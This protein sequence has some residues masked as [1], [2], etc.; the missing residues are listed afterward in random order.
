M[1]Y[2]VGAVFKVGFG[3]R[4]V[5]ERGGKVGIKMEDNSIV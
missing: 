4:E 1:T 2:D 3:L 5:L